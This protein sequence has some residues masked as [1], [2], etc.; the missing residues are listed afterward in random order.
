MSQ[1]WDPRRATAMKSTPASGLG[2]TSKMR[3]V[4][5]SARTATKVHAHLQSPKIGSKQYG[6]RKKFSTPTATKS[7]LGM[8]INEIR[9]GRGELDGLSIPRPLTMQASNHPQRAARK[10]EPTHPS[11]AKPVDGRFYIKNGQL[12]R[13][14]S[15][16]DSDSSMEE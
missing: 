7:G 11:H 4:P 15:D 14:E 3:S 12:K 13:I 10:L 2:R 16:E 9:G 5:P 1:D 8:H 6:G